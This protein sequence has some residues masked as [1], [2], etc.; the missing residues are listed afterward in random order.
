[1]IV[2]G[3]G[4][5]GN[6]AA[7]GLASQ[8][9]SVTV[10]DS[11]RVIGDK[12]CTGIVGSECLRRF[13]I[14]PALVYHHSGAA[15][16]VMPQGGALRFEAPAPL[17]GVV[18]RVA[19]VDSFARQAQAAGARYLLG[20]KV[21][22]AQVDGAGVTVL[23]AG[24]CYRARSLVLAAGFG[25]PLSRQLGLG[26][27]PDYAVG[28][29]ATVSADN[30]HDVEVHLGQ[31]VAPGFFS[32]VVPTRPGQALAGLLAR[33]QAPERLAAFIQTL[34]QQGKITAVVREPACWGIPLRPLKRTYRDRVLVVGDTAG[35]V[36]PIT[37]G[38]IYYSL[39]S[40]ELAASTLG[41][42]LADDDLSAARLS[43]Y[44]ERWHALLAAEL[45]VGYCA[46]RMFEMLN[47]QQVGFLLRS[48]LGAGA[49]SQL[50]EGAISFDWHGRVISRLLGH[51]A[52]GGVMHL[53]SPLLCGLASQTSYQPSAFSHQETAPPGGVMGS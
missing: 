23:T 18:D 15:L 5:A 41:A 4:P 27:V 25:S 1:M 8:G 31:Q 36:K 28:A 49:R 22:Q 13:P 34:R 45:D 21:V 52:L 2:V 53:L 51:T 47:D 20:Q 16:L 24:E 14:D 33:R 19:Y 38:G 42:A 50:A 6:G 3:A 43:Q 17:A 32:W 11:R 10:I 37:G 35:Q 12:L 40:G 46:R 29:Q 48:A 26:S 7:L 30:I 39:M 9:L 44:Q